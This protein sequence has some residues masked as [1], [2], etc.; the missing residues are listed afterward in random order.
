MVKSAAMRALL[1]FAATLAPA[2]ALADGLEL[3]LPLAC[4]MAKTCWVQQYADHDPS[5]GVRDYHCGA[6]S[7]DG[8]DGTDIRIRDTASDVAVLAA[9]SGVVKAVR[10]GVADRLVKTGQDREAVG[11][12]EC[13]NGVLVSHGGGWE[14]QYCHLRRGSI[15]VEAGETVDTG[16]QLGL[17]GYSGMAA[18][19]HLHLTVRKDGKPVDPF[20]PDGQ[21]ACGPASGS[22]WSARS[23]AV[24]AYQR[25]AIIRAGFAPA[26]VSLEDLETGGH[27][28]AAQGQPSAAWP[29]MVAYG[30][31]INLEAGDEIAVRVEGPGSFK[32][33]SLQRLDRRKAQF[34]LFTGKKKPPP[35]DYNGLF[36]VVRDGKVQ[37]EEHW[38]ARIE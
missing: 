30:W 36:Q 1:F 18:F 28:I 26:P 13:G 12:R 31:A 33:E 24:L 35:G 32:A 11:T 6:E 20:Q 21:A 5:T 27:G 25:G 17:A 2:S 7:Y 37:L 34:M 8:H 19:P 14:T 38:T 4:E 22:L 10:D 15:A 23:G 9:A 16:R 29:A 3:E